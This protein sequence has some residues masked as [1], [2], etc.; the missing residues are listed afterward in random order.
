VMGVWTLGTI[1]PQIAHAL[2]PGVSAEDVVGSPYAIARYEVDPRLGGETALANLRSRLARRSIGLVV[3]FVPNHTARDHDW[4][5]SHPELYVTDETGIVCG[6]DPYFPAWTD[7][8][9]LDHRLAATR[10]QML[11]TLASIAERA[12]GVRCDMAML[13]LSDVFAKTWA[14]VPARGEL[15]RGEF[16]AEAIDS[17]PRTFTWIAEAYWGLERRLQQL[18]FGFTYDKTLYD[19][20][21]HGDAGRIRQHLT[22]SIEVQARAV[23]FLENHDE[24]RLA[25]SLSPDRAAAA[26]TIAMTVPGMRF[27]H[28]GQLDGRRRHATIQLAHR[29]DE[30]PDR[31]V[32]AVHDRL[33]RIEREGSFATLHAGDDRLIAYRWDDPDRRLVV[34]VNFSDASVQ[35]NVALDLHGTAGRRLVLH[36]LLDGARYERSGSA[37]LY[38]ELRPWQAHVFAVTVKGL[39]DE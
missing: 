37:P 19:D 8:A 23:R 18:G 25:A 16:W 38:V 28:E 35:S 12:D 32:R 10:R 2:F 34:I 9:Q 6:K 21:L 20:L 13:V 33:L 4:V 36:D 22:E 17:L 14:D 1:G 39:W 11:T 30:A 3:D 24:P 5:R 29:P 7:T 31:G 26:L 15:A 27:V